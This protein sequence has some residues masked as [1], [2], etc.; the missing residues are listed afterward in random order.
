M[1][2]LEEA[3]NLYVKE[4]GKVVTFAS[5]DVK[6]RHLIESLI[7]DDSIEQAIS[8]KIDEGIY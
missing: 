6:K 7:A 3:S 1:S 4:L 5:P 8:E 2:F